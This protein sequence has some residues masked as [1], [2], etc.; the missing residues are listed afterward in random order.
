MTMMMSS[1][2]WVI[3][4]D[5]RRTLC[6]SVQQTTR[7][8]CF[9]GALNRKHQLG[10][11]GLTL[12]LQNGQIGSYK[13]NN[14]NN[15]Q[16]KSSLCFRVITSRCNATINS[17]CAIWGKSAPPQWGERTTPAGRA[18][19]PSGRGS[20]L[21]CANTFIGWGGPVRRSQHHNN[22]MKRQM[23]RCDHIFLMDRRYFS[24][25]SIFFKFI[26]YASF[27]FYFYFFLPKICVINDFWW[28][29]EM[30]SALILSSV[31]SLDF[32]LLRLL[33]YEVE[34]CQFWPNIVLTPQWFLSCFR[35]PC[36][37]CVYSSQIQAFLPALSRKGAVVQVNV[38]VQS[39]WKEESPYSHCCHVQES[40]Q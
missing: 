2:I 34:W 31:F 11:G 26:L 16:H 27:L 23:M 30:F 8:E 28:P 35:F 39:L 25:V 32:L 33:D 6:C 18:G 9:K 15:T 19:K 14:N 13:K 21:R 17:H 40:R 38:M 7:W 12:W 36:L 29:S 37:M 22:W 5:F 20:G 3:A 24:I 4:G 1:K 10:V